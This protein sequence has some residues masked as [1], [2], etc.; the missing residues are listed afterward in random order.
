MS[1]L[2]IHG[3]FYQPPRFDPWLD[4]VLPE[5]SAAPFHNWN[6]RIDRESYAPLAYARRMDSQGYVFN[7]I[8][9]YEYISFNFGPTLLSWMERHSPDTYAR[10]LEGDRKSIQHFGHGN[11][12]AQAYHHIIMPLSTDHDRNIE[13]SWSI[14]D[15]EHRYQRK[16]EGMWVGETAVCTDTLEALAA[17]GIKFT[18]L[19]P[20]Q[21]ESV[22]PLD[23][24]DWRRIDEGTLDTDQ[25]YLIQLPSGNEIS[26]FFYDGPLSQAVAFEKLLRDGGGFWHRLTSRKTTA[27]LSLATDGESYGHHFKF[28]EMA[29]AYALEQALKDDSPLQL[30]NYASYL[31]ENPPTMKVRIWEKS[32]WSCVHGVERWRDDCGCTDGGHPDWNQRWRRPLRRSLNLLKYYLDEHYRYKGPDYFKDPQ[33]ALLDYGQCLCSALTRDDFIARHQVKNLDESQKVNA[34][35]LLEMQRVGLAS[36]ASCAWF[37]D[38]VSRIE[39][40]NALSYAL[41]GLEMMQDLDGLDVEEQ[42]LEVLEEAFSNDQ[43]LGD[44]REVW[45]KLVKPRKIGPTQLAVVGISLGRDREFMSFPGMDFS[46]QKSDGQVELSYKWNK[47]GETSKATFT[48]KDNKNCVCPSVFSDEDRVMSLNMLDRR[49]R[50]YILRVLEKD[51]ELQIWSVAA[52][53]G[54]RL[55]PFLICPFEEGQSVPLAGSGAAGPGIIQYF[56]SLNDAAEDFEK[57]WSEVIKY[58]PYIKQLLEQRVTK[59]LDNLTDKDEPDWGRAANLASRSVRLGVFPDL[60][61]VQNRLWESR[62]QIDHDILRQLFIRQ[63]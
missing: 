12:M 22:A 33:Q 42:F 46:V 54:A 49:L 25:P 61:A 5:A 23:S 38:E 27:M 62:N 26:V 51:A 37:F 7:I 28:G 59:I 3:H 53:H 15:F 40:L 50:D 34:L 20:R 6:Q 44:G 36:F 18:I 11:A 55:E 24:D 47:T 45:R 16:P 57:Y 17:A 9:C 39:P 29:L 63:G 58:N 60:F 14:A 30:T 1:H 21:A 43:R 31:A 48:L 56:L 35:K 8:N 13:I 52:E 32:S 4:E 10:I 19:A 41:R 2:C